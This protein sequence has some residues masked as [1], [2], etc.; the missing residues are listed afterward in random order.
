MKKKI[1]GVKTF[2]RIGHTET[3]IDR[4]I[5]DAVKSMYLTEKS[6]FT[7]RIRINSKKNN[8]GLANDEVW[9]RLGTN[10]IKLFLS[11]IYGFS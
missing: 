8:L 10:V 7:L 4:S 3:D 6:S 1:N 11:V 9:I 2:Y 5:E